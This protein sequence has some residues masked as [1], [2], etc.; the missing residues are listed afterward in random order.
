MRYVR[1]PCQDDHGVAHV[2]GGARGRVA[3]PPGSAAGGSDRRGGE[4]VSKNVPRRHVRRWV[5]WGGGAA[6]GGCGVATGPA[7]IWNAVRRCEGRQSPPLALCLPRFP[8]RVL[9]R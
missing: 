7:Q 4:T 1:E 5:V 9:T 2:A 8:A 3:G 6:G